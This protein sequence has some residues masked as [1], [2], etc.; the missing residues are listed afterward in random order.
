MLAFLDRT[1]DQIDRLSVRLAA[2]SP[3]AAVGIRAAIRRTLRALRTRAQ[4][5]V[6][7]EMARIYGPASTALTR[8]ALR[9]LQADTFDDL[10]SATQNVQDD[11]KR[12]TRDL[13]KRRTELQVGRGLPPREVGKQLAKDLDR[14]G[15]KFMDSAGRR[16]NL[17]AYGKMVVRTKGAQAHNTGGILRAVE[18]GVSEFRVLDGTNDPACA[19]ANG[20]RWSA[21]R[22]LAEPVAH[23]NC[24]RGFAPVVP[25]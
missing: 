14:I 8:N 1:Q 22:C 9:A 5:W 18:S 11:M 12:M 13:A 17:N 7:G 6:D 3:S 10:A 25:R 2:A 4:Q 15:L 24:T 21:A 19:R 20:S 23:P 16:W